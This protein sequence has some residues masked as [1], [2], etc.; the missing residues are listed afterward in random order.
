[1]QKTVRRVV[2]LIDPASQD[3]AGTTVEAAE[4]LLRRAPGE[5]EQLAG[6]FALVARDG[7]NV[8]MARSLDR[9]L[10][11][12]L[13][14]EPEGP[15]LV[16]AERIDQI[17]DCLAENGYA[18]QF[19]PSYTR[20]VPAHHVTTLRLVGCPDPNPSHTRFFDPP[21]AT[22][23]SDLTEIGERYVRSLYAEARAWVEG[24][25][26]DEP[27][28][29]LFSG[30]IDSGAVLVA[31]ERAVRDLGQSP[32]RL[33]AFTLAVD[34]GGED[35]SQAR[36]FLRR[37]GLEMLHEPI[38][39]P[40]D[41]LDAAE[42][43]RVI[44]DYKP[45]DVE[46]ATVALALLRGI[47]ERYP[48]WRYLADGDGG[49]EN[50]KGLSD[51][52]ESGAFDS[53]RG[54][55]LDALSGGLGRRR[56]EALAHLHRRLQPVVRPHLGAAA[57]LRLR[58]VQ[59]LHAARGGAGGR[60]H[61]VR[62]AHPRLDRG[63]LRPQGRDRPAGRSRL[64]R[65]RLPGVR[66]TSLPARR[67]ARR[68][69]HGT[70][71]CRRRQLPPRVPRALRGQR[72]G[73]LR[74]ALGEPGAGPARDR[75]VRERRPPKPSIDPWR[76][77]DVLVEPERVPGGD[78]VD[79]VTVFLAGS[80]CPFTC[81]FCDL[82]RHTIEGSTPKGALPRQI[83]AALAGIEELAPGFTLKLYNASNFFEPRAVPPEDED[84][85]LELSA[86][87]GRLVVECH[88]NL[89]GERCFRF[90]ERA[91]PAVEIA[92]GLETVHPQA[93]PRLNKRMEVADFDRAA[94]ELG[95]RGIAVRAF[96]LLGAPFVPQAEQVAWTV[97]SVEHALE[98][99]AGVV[100]LIPMRGGNGEMEHLQ[101]AGDFHPPSLEQLEAALDGALALVGERAGDG[102]GED[103]GTDAVVQ[104]DAWDLEDLSGCLRCTARRHE[105]LRRIGLSGEPE[106]P[107]AC[108]ICAGQR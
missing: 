103:A 18:H 36:E 27:I 23:S 45:L 48:E 77:L 83:R 96:V 100:T 37:T 4:E 97:R 26:K 66:E 80:E 34:G 85:I 99:G 33:K 11:Y 17:L 104:V 91:S 78:T 90:A 86:R 5:L 62:R 84:E 105:R 8:L 7:E 52:G 41:A 9:P 3:L 94:R 13:A 21:R 64:L 87:A 56:G 51:R 46:C 107:I 6:S 43:V 50:L 81:V 57:A 10:R 39:V 40:A 74:S 44:E 12:F 102:A 2:N 15:M 1:M 82:W 53:Q 73:R 54:E 72:T 59:P 71:R 30:G 29:V 35:L 75:Q 31:V 47:R 42:A 20:M 25:D 32:A 68:G 49:D 24:L 22:G 88:P 108:P 95:E 67:G 98:Q 28:G 63:A 55:Q 38:E 79:S 14:K 76:P 19:H 93:L 89:V 58:R 70:L 92:M 16:V 101:R 106:A 65:R 69:L 61:P 60:G